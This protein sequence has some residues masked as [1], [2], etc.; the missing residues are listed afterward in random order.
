MGRRDRVAVG[1]GRL[2]DYGVR[3]LDVGGRGH[4]G[5]RGVI[6]PRDVVRHGLVEKIINAYQTDGAAAKETP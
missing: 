6:S 1:H 3:G 4:I 5:L 2:G